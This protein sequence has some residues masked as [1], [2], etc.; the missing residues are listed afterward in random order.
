MNIDQKYL[1]TLLKPL[2]NE[3]IITIA[4][5]FNDLEKLKVSY[6]DDN[7][8]MDEKFKTHLN[9]MLLKN[10]ISDDSGVS[11]LKA[12]GIFPALSGFSIISNKKIMKVEKEEVAM[13]QNF[14]IKTF[15]AQ[16]AQLGNGNTQN[17]TINM[18]ELV[19]KVAASGDKEAKGILMKL[20]ENPT[21]SGVIGAG[22]SGFIGLLS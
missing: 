13:A 20:L 3:N 2:E 19:E 15:N 7:K 21:I 14:N 11:T 8:N 6:V 17:V 9:Y 1:S 12:I 16:N 5:Y 4:E 10:M 18:Q 22:V